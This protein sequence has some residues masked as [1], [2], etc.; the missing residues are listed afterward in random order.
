MKKLHTLIL[1]FA[2]LVLAACSDN[3][4]GSSSPGNSNCGKDIKCLRIDAENAFRAGD[5]K[6]SYSICSTMV[7]DVAP[8]SSFGYFG[9]AKASLWDR[10]INPL[11]LFY[12]AKPPKKGECP[13]MKDE[14]TTMKKHNDLYQVMKSVTAA[15]SELDRRDTLTV[16]YERY[17][18][19]DV[20]ALDTV[21]TKFIETFCSGSVQN[22]RDTTEK[23]E[24]FPLSDREYKSTYFRS[25][26]LLASFSKGV[27]GLSDTDNNG[28]LTVNRNKRGSDSTKGD[29]PTGFRKDEWTDWGCLNNDYRDLPIALECPEDSLGNITV[30]I[31]SAK[32]LDDLQD[33]LNEYYKCLADPEQD[34]KSCVVPSGVGDVNNTIDG[35]GDDFKGVEDVLGNLGLMGSS[36]S[37]LKEDV[38]KYKA[39]ASF[40]KMGTHIDEDGDGCIDEELLDGL[41]NDGDGFVNENG[42]LASVDPDNE[43]W[44]GVNRINNS[45]RGSNPYKDE[46]NKAYNKP[47]RDHYT[48]FK[49]CNG[50][51]PSSCHYPNPDS[52]D[53]ATVLAF[54]QE[55]GYWTL[56]NDTPMNM[57]LKLAVA[58]DTVCG[59]LNFSLE[60][61]KAL[62]GGCWPNYD[63]KKF[64]E[65]WLKRKLA[66]P[67][68][69]AKRVHQNCKDC[70]GADCLKKK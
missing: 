44:Y 39:Y 60:E 6:G 4:F 65:Y 56:G 38:E 30:V 35:F 22:C 68:D 33:D 63:D 51:S 41:D 70:E 53:M 27:L 31:N 19:G 3:L 17:K 49:I 8:T 10:G 20:D 15:L 13:F 29:F 9:M 16:L 1:C 14:S 2:L 5:F 12:L 42:R 66:S 50:P 7:A 28:C 59:E 62:I 64:I 43:E 40:Y 25:I 26:L 61:R 32:I 45:M 11:S 24:S 21:M 46:T 54:T 67:D 34:D 48:K 37:G 47:L 55:P 36:S 18:K 58:Q 57:A 69:Q 23:R 52:T